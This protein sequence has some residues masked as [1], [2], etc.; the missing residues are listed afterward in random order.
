M[1]AQWVV[2]GNYLVVTVSSMRP[3]IIEK[4]TANFERI[5]SLLISNVPDEQLLIEID[6]I[7]KIK[8]C[9]K[10]AGAEGDFS[11][12]R[13]TGI[14]EIDGVV[15]HDA[16]VDRIVEFARCNLPYLPLLN[17]WRNVQLNP[18]EESKQHL[19]LFLE[20]NKMQITHDGC[21]VAYKGVEK[22]RNGD[23]VDCH[24]KTFCN[25]VGAVV[26]M[27]RAMVNPDRNVTCSSGLHVAA[28]GYVADTYQTVIEV[29]V[30]PRDVVAV[31]NDYNNQ[32]MRV[33]RYE[34]VA[35]N[36]GAPKDVVTKPLV[37][38]SEEDEMRK[39]G[40]GKQK[41]E[42]QAVLENLK[43]T[44]IGACVDLTGLT[45]GEVVEVTIAL[46]AFC[47]TIDTTNL[48]NIDKKNK[49]SIVKKASALLIQA[50]YTVATF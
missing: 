29:K 11:I 17:F 19:F 46:C 33:C 1:A 28:W 32:K 38:K 4:G 21:F 18:S 40:I 8:A 36:I 47:E 26:I 20:A 22:N 15:V 14:V 10:Q 34:V 27:D 39:E 30:N 5:M 9:V 45:A 16:I 25:N 12:D 35:I 41:K 48:A 3:V 24:T 31:P 7:E 44:E 42:K 49:K 23:Y 50:G 37:D 43:E 13:D 6:M 2:T